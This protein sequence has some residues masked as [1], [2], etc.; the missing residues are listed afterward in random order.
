MCT[1]MWISPCEPLPADTTNRLNIVWIHIW[2]R[3]NCC[4]LQ[5]FLVQLANISVTHFSLKTAPNWLPTFA[6]IGCRQI[7]KGEPILKELIGKP[8]W[9]RCSAYIIAVRLN[10]KQNKILK[11][12]F[13]VWYWNNTL[14]LYWVAF[15]SMGKYL[16]NICYQRCI[17]TNQPYTQRTLLP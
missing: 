3:N 6:N 2:S 4:R 1:C 16:N 13:K 8:M 14:Q 10:K 17:H 7:P 9:N 15:K 12:Y 11:K 5:R